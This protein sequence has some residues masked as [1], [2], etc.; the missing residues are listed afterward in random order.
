[1]ERP[2][3]TKELQRMNAAKDEAAAKYPPQYS[4]HGGAYPHEGACPACRAERC[5]NCC[6]GPLGTVM[7]GRCTNGR[8]RGCHQ[9]VC[10]PGGDT[11]PGHGFGSAARAYQRAQEVANA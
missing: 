9:A 7:E 8:C 3:T 6:G 5:C 2:L 1:M 4:Q 10:T 11:S